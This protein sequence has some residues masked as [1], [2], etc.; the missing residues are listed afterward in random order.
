MDSY[1]LHPF[2]I[3]LPSNNLFVGKFE[4][5][6]CVTRSPHHLSLKGITTKQGFSSL[7]HLLPLPNCPIFLVRS[8]IV[9]ILL[10]YRFFE[11][12]V[13]Y[14]F[15]L[16]SPCWT[17]VPVGR[18][19]FRSL[20]GV[21]SEPIL[22]YFFTQRC[23]F[24]SF[25]PYSDSPEILICGGSSTGAGFAL[26]NCITIAPESPNATWTLERMVSRIISPSLLL[27]K[28]RWYSSSFKPSKRVMPL[29]PSLP[30]G[31][32]LILNGSLQGL[33][34]FDL[35]SDSQLGRRVVLS[36]STN[37]ITDVYLEQYYR[38]PVISLGGDLVARR[39]RSCFWFWPTD[40]LP[41]WH[42]RVSRRISYWGDGS[43][44]SLPF[45]NAN[46][47]WHYFQV[48]VPPY[49]T[50]GFTQP[51]FDISVTD[52]AYG[53]QYQI[54]NVNLVQNSGLRV[55]LVAGKFWFFTSEG[56]FHKILIMQQLLQARDGLGIPFFQWIYRYNAMYMQPQTVKN[57]D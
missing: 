16:L 47:S 22:K 1:N 2:V 8:M 52:W 19:A 25:P 54:T 3:V 24:A 26:D 13:W 27:M 10:L 5:F 9:R 28:R 55:S 33:A 51:T 44:L 34:G 36:D 32:F 23:S 49:L 30:Y 40:Q 7:W 42:C 4:I 48:Y 56:F 21:C 11:F 6:S 31:T 14:I 35:A 46:P 53:G 37:W 57:V 50:Q 18:Q 39:T 17:Y 20:S 41:Q 43:F 38:C 15:F 45:L 12:V 29:I